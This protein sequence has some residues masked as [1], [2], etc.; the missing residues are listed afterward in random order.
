MFSEEKL[1]QFMEVLSSRAPT[2]G[3]GS[4]S[5]LS[6]AVG[7]SL[8]AMV[9]NLTIGKKKYADVTEDMKGILQDATLLRKEME[10]LIEKDA[11]SF[12]AVMSAF[13]MPKETEEEKRLRKEKIEYATKLATRVPLEVMRKCHS[14]LELCAVVSEKGNRN[15]VSDAGVASLQLEVGAKGAM[16][17]VLIN[18]PGIEDEGFREEVKKEAESIYQSVESKS[19]VILETVKSRM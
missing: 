6:G 15:S 11:R 18:L 16:L 14:G 9:A 4:A 17:N 7:A 1:S 5:A 2:P 12:D 13:K 8:V 19:R 10:D 3:G